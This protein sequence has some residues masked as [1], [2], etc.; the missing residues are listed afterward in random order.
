MPGLRAM[1]AHPMVGGTPLLLGDRVVANR[2]RYERSGEV[3][4]IRV[5]CWGDHKMETIWHGR[6]PE[7][8]ED[9]Y[10]DP[11]EREQVW[12]TLDARNEIFRVD[13]LEREPPVA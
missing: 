2:G 4:E 8:G 10:A 7:T 5:R 1:K 9:R 6:D 3:T 13:Q 11:V 12:I